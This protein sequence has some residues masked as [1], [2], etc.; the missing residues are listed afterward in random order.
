[1]GKTLTKIDKEQKSSERDSQ[2]KPQRRKNVIKCL[3]KDD[4]KQEFEK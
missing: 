3:K 4:G 1:M 2:N